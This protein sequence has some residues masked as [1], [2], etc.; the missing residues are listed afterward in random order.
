M[1]INPK[2]WGSLDLAIASGVDFPY[3][4]YKMA[5]DGDVSPVSNYK[6]GTK[7]IWPF[8]DDFLHVLNK[9][10]DLKYFLSDLFNPYVIK[11]IDVNDLNPISFPVLEGLSLI[12]SKFIGKY[13]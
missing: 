8:P 5:V 13:H 4:L 7:F 9:P 6:L 11:N 10:Q 2:F 12:I 1:E 3:L